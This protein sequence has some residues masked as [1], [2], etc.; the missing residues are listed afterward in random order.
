VILRE[1]AVAL[2]PRV[3]TYW[4]VQGALTVAFLAALVIAGA[5]VAA[6]LDATL[7]AGLVGGIGGL[8]IL[9]LAA[10]AFV[11]A[12]LDFRRFR[13]EVMELGL[14][15]A[16]GWLWRQHQ[17]I[18]HARIQTVDTTAG[19]LMRRLGL[20]SVEVQ[21]ASAAGSTSIPG[22]TPEVADALVAELAHRAGIEEGT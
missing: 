15:V 5:V 22:L 19:P 6:V 2:D 1:P 21:T 7:V 18:P 13:Y 4:L 14:Y 3:R 9:I 10:L 17:I 12:E 16:R 8:V 11:S 20:V